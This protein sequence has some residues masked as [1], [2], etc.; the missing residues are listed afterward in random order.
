MG[1]QEYHSRRGSDGTSSYSANVDGKPYT[2]GS[3]GKP[4]LDGVAEREKAS[5]K[6]LEERARQSGTTITSTTTIRIIS[7]ES[8]KS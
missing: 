8:K 1:R 5:Q 3:G 6:D 2:L 7:R 4:F